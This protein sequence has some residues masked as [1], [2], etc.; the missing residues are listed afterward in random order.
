MINKI[1]KGPFTLHREGINCIEKSLDMQVSV[2]MPPL[3]PFSRFFP[4]HN[5]INQYRYTLL[6]HYGFRS[7][8][9]VRQ[10]EQKYI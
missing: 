7:A 6:L 3:Q 5:L 1:G 9:N 8:Y 10:E 2:L 4:S